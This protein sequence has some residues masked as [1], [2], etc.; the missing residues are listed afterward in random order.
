MNYFEIEYQ[1]T[2]HD[3]I[4]HFVGYADVHVF[5]DGRSFIEM[6][7]EFELPFAADSAGQYSINIYQYN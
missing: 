1:P 4:G 3:D 2:N 5:I 6:V 7:K